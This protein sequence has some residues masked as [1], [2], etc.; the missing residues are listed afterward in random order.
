MYVCIHKHSTEVR[1]Y[2]NGKVLK[3]F[4]QEGK[5]LCATSTVIIECQMFRRIEW[6]FIASPVT[7]VNHQVYL[8]WEGGAMKNFSKE[9]SL[10]ILR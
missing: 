8:I 6:A 10:Q 5:Y 1:F 3:S 2:T 9:T 4:P 7:D